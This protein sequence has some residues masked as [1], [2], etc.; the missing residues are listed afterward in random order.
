MSGR[1]FRTLSD[2]RQKGPI[3]D[4]S[5][6]DALARSIRHTS[7][8]RTILAGLGSLCVAALGNAG[9][10]EARKRKK[11][12]QPNAYGCLD[13]G[14]KCGGSDARCCSG[15]CQGKKPKKGKPDKRVCA[16]HNVLT[17]AA[18]QDSCLQGNQACGTSGL[19]LQT[20]GKADY[21]GNLGICAVCQ[22]D[23]DCEAMKGPGAACVI[24]AAACPGT[25]GTA[26]YAAAG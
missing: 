23:A 22:G 25:G 2:I 5:H 20:T 24:C 19:C 10:A 16:A 15:I 14:Q 6:F 7:S 26:C 1:T 17:C 18:G 11:K 8:R 12:P 21:C 4:G 13:V 9:V 3:M